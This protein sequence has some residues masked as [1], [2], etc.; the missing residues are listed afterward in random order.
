MFSQ[1]KIV[2]STTGNPFFAPQLAST[3]ISLSNGDSVVVKMG[4]WVGILGGQ[5]GH[6]VTGCL[7]GHV[8]SGRRVVVGCFVV[9]V[10]GYSVPPGNEPDIAG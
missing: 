4:D 6:S 3:G 7:V 5:F 2:S 1:K 9:I 10:T 8:V